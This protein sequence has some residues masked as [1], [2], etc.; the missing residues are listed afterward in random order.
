MEN[1]VKEYI[2]DSAYDSEHIFRLCAGCESVCEHEKIN[3][4]LSTGVDAALPHL[5]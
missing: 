2:I 4:D 1:Y 3:Q 5:R